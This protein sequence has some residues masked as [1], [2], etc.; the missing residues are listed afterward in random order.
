MNKIDTPHSFTADAVRA[1]K[2][3]E[4]PK[5][6]GGKLNPTALKIA[7]Q[8]RR[9]PMAQVKDSGTLR[10]AEFALLVLAGI[11]VSL[12]YVGAPVAIS[13]QYLVTILSGGAIAVIL[14][15]VSDGYRM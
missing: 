7:S 10:L 2:D 13:L 9:D 12:W 14:L 4:P 8:Y 11:G 3:G 1:H 6:A 5:E 15:E